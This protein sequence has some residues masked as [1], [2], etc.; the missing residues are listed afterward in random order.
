MNRGRE[1]VYREVNPSLAGMP[2][3]R[4]LDEYAT[5]LL[6]TLSSVEYTVSYS[7]GYCPVRLGDCVRL[8]YAKAGITD[9]KAKV[10]NQSINCSSGC[11]VT[12][13]AVFTTKLWR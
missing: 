8:N 9:V 13:T 6:K 10:I 2:S 7:H 4:Q 3:Q 11:Q 5:N 1:I 12:E